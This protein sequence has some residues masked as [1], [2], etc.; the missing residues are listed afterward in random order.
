MLL[1]WATCLAQ[2][3]PP[4][5][6][7]KAYGGNASDIPFGLDVL[8]TN[9]FIGGQ[10]LSGVSGNKTTGNYG[11]GDYWVMMLSGDG[12]K[13]W[14]RTFGGTANE[15]LTCLQQT[16]D[17]GYILGG[18]SSSTNSGTKTGG[19]YGSG[20]FW[21]VRLNSIG[22]QLW[23]YSY[24]G[25]SSEIIWSLQQTADHGFILAGAS[26]SGANGNKTTTK[27]GGIGNDDIWLVRLDAN[28]NQIWDASFGGTGVDQAHR[29]LEL[30]T[31]GFLIGSDTDSGI[32]GNKTN[33]S[34][35]GSDYWII[36][37]D[38]NGQRI[39]DR[40]FGGNSTEYLYDMIQTA[41]D[42]FI[43]AGSSTS[44]IS[45][46]KTTSSFGGQDFWILKLDVAGNIQWQKS[47]GGNGHEE[48]NSIYQTTDGG[49]LVGGY[50]YSGISGSKTATNYGSSDGWVVRLDANGNKL[51]DNSYG[52]SGLDFI[53]RVGQ[54]SDGGYFISLESSSGVSGNK[55]I[56][57]FGGDDFWLI[58]VGP[59]RP[60]LTATQAMGNLVLSWPDWKLGFH[61][62]ETGALTQPQWVT[63]SYVSVTNGG[64][65]SVTISQPQGIKFF[66]LAR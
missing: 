16:D 17:G 46:N 9:F 53:T 7:Q 10:S 40:V 54:P 42:G 6:W 4:I 26:A 12:N 66:R 37:I 3:P 22:N 50:S 63:N 13:L 31:G 62:E 58:K 55:T 28:G 52:G 51:W 35:G 33:V 29:I 18:I 27:L 23:D 20:D 60:I 45:G 21:V 11:A 41:D 30:R 57:G 39:W 1:F 19:S 44:G 49:F 59:E 14:E 56:P 43:L 2:L 25:T 15:A 65:I 32:S 47:Y 36:R 48:P 38:A 64:V 61:L 24:G 8:E 34:F 5:Q